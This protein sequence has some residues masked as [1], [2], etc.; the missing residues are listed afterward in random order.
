M[1]ASFKP[2][3]ID[4]HTLRLIVGLSAIFLASLTVLLAG[5][6]LAS[7]SDAYH[8]GGWARDVL[9]GILFA[10]ASFLVAYNGESGTEM[11]LSKLAAVAALGVALFPCDCGTGQEI[12]PYV[13]YV[14]A[15]VLFAVLAWFCLLFYRRARGKGHREALWRSWL[16]GLCRAVIVSVLLVL[17]FDHFAGGPFSSMVPRLVFYGEQAALIAFGVSWLVASR[18]LPGITAPRERI[19]VLPVAPG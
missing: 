12:L 5:Q 6:P 14:S 4:H 18:V 9:V 7:I 16:Y 13:H 8:Q 3:E 19:S 2:H 17:A 10:I 11:L 1:K 15:A